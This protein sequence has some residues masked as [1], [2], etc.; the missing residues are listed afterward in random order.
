MGARQRQHG[1]RKLSHFEATCQWAELPT[2]ITNLTRARLRWQA[3]ASRCVGRVVVP[4]HGLDRAGAVWI[5]RIDWAL[6]NVEL[7]EVA[8]ASDSADDSE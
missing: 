7:A 2:K 8:V 4:T 3:L 1:I 5:A 6:M